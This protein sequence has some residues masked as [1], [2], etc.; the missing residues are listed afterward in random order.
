MLIRTFRVRTESVGHVHDDEVVMDLS[1]D[2]ALV[3]A[4]RANLEALSPDDGFEE[5]V[6]SYT[7]IAVMFRRYFVLA[8][9]LVSVFLRRNSSNSYAD[10]RS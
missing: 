1:F 2:F 9:F 4:L 3:P 7:Y 10:G 6:N 5:K 8:H